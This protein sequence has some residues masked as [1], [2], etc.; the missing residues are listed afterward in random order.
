M[1]NYDPKSV[2]K[3][4][5]NGAFGGMSLTCVCVLVSLN[6]FDQQWDGANNVKGAAT[7]CM[8]V[9][10]K[11]S[12]GEKKTQEESGK[13]GLCVCHIPF[14]IATAGTRRQ[15]KVEVELFNVC[16]LLNILLLK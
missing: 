7:K 13:F 3:L 5:F 14:I 15:L 2:T 12:G 9:W 11:E 8:F 16:K 1:A 4:F 10:E 6:F